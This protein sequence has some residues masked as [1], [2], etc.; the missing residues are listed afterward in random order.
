MLAAVA[1]VVSGTAYAAIPQVRVIVIGTATTTT[2]ATSNVVCYGCHKSLLPDLKRASVHQPFAKQA[3]TV[4]HI[5]HT[6]GTTPSGL[7]LPVEQ[8]CF[9]C[10]PATAQAMAAAHTHAPFASGGCLDC[11]DPHGS[12]H[13]T[14]LVKSPADLCVS[15]HSMSAEPGREWIHEPVAQRQC[16]TCHE[17]HG[18]AY[19][20]VL[21]S[22]E[23]ELCAGC[24]PTVTASAQMSFQHQPFVDNPCTRCHE[25]HFASVPGLLVDDESTL[26]FG[27]HTST[28]PLS[29]STHQMG[30]ASECGP[31]HNPH[32]SN[33]PALLPVGENGVCLHCHDEGSLVWVEGSKH[34]AQPCWSCHDVH[35][36]PADPFLAADATAVCLTCHDPMDFGDESMGGQN[37]HPVGSAYTDV[38]TGGPLTC[39]STCHAPHG[40]P[41]G[42]MLKQ[43]TYPMDGNC[44]IC[45]G[46]LPGE[47]V[48]VDF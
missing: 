3:C 9:K 19:P 32:A 15:C 43:F 44:L 35:N 27:C 21:R 41:N 29:G 10:H 34:A 40:S 30:S 39:V 47:T 1:V 36:A 22:S 31:C 25:S 4:C 16:T 23:R 33:Y 11:H 13:A 12:D 8:L 17:A 37:N 48:G 6:S 45:H 46:V 26:C 38:N 2:S 42:Y 24:H 5:K 20:S 7:V 28:Q 14:L 18:S